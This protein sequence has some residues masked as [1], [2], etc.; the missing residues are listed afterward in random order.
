MRERDIGNNQPRRWN[1][2]FRDPN[3]SEESLRALSIPIIH[4]PR[5]CH[6]GIQ[7]VLEYE[8]QKR[9]RI[10]AR[11]NGLSQQE[12][13]ELLERYPVHAVAIPQHPSDSSLWTS[14]E[15]DE[16]YLLAILDGHHRARYTSPSVKNLP[17]LVMTVDQASEVYFPRYKK[18][19][20]EFVSQVV[21]EMN[22]ALHSFVHAKESLV[23]YPVYFFEQAGKKEVGLVGLGG[24][25]THITSVQRT[26]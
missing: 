14:L 4:V 13:I 7:T 25:K 6:F 18:G 8:Q 5:G 10:E 3:A 9:K 19:P 1:Y 2:E 15:N 12:I 20:A 17:T 11:Y 23:P 24:G 21:R 26:A 22:E 16:V